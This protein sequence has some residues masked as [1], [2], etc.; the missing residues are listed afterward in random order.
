MPL[1]CMKEIQNAV[2][3]MMITT[4][5]SPT[6]TMVTVRMRAVMTQWLPMLHLGQVIMNKHVRMGK[7]VMVWVWLLSSMT[8]VTTST[9]ILHGRKETNKRRRKEGKAVQKRRRKI[10]C[11]GEIVPAVTLIVGQVSK[12]YRGKM[13]KHMYFLSRSSP[14]IEAFCDSTF[15]IFMILVFQ[16]HISI[17]IVLR[18]ARKCM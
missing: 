13:K 6:S 12:I 18:S 7:I 14:R 16:C 11:S 17:S 4:F 10:W 5:T 8:G 1:P 2:E 3:M 15:H 9:S